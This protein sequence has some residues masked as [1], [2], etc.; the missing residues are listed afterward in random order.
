[1]VSPLSPQIRP[2]LDQV[3]DR[4][5]PNLWG[6]GSQIIGKAK[7]FLVEKWIGVERSLTKTY[8]TD[9]CPAINPKTR[10]S[11]TRKHFHQTRQ[12]LR[13][14]SEAVIHAG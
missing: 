9:P 12:G 10:S 6:E 1:M 8:L 3:A 11:A 14:P 4:F 7:S 13:G 2:K 5:R